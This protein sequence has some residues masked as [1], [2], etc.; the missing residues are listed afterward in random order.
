[1][2]KRSI[3]T[4]PEKFFLASISDGYSLERSVRNFTLDKDDFSIPE[5]TKVKT[6]EFIGLTYSRVKSDLEKMIQKS[7][8][9]SFQNL[10]MGDVIDSIKLPKKIGDPFTHHENSIYVP[11]IGTSDVVSNSKDLKIKPQNY[12]Q[13]TLSKDVVDSK[14]ATAF[15]NSKVGKIAREALKTGAIAHLPRNRLHMIPLLLP[16]LE[17]QSVIASSYDELR[18]IRSKLSILEDEFALRPLTSRKSL[19]ELRATAESFGNISAEL[20]VLSTIEGGE[21][22]TTEF[23][24][25]FSWDI[26]E[27]KKA[28]YLIHSC[29]KTVVAFLN[30]EGGILLIGV[31]DDG[32]VTGLEEEIEKLFKNNDKFLNNFKDHIKRR[33]GVEFFPYI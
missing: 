7:D 30:T 23:K 1:V 28:E 21:T 29:L 15:L 24:Q 3:A 27:K 6:S 12:Y 18:S 14:Y 25:T 8:Y 33:I 22:K 11:R 4:R 32:E 19:N 16:A 9:A 10:Q 2:G 20:K 5:G 17:T 26:K 13:I 31:N